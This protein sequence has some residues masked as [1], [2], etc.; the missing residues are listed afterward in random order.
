MA[1]RFL[2]FADSVP[3]FQDEGCKLGLYPI[4]IKANLALTSSVYE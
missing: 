2:G 1:P 3:R 4:V